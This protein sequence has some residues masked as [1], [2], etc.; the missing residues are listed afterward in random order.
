MTVAETIA[1]LQK[2]PQD[3]EVYFDCPRCGEA[4]TIHKTTKAVVVETKR[5]P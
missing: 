5:K 4:N 1:E 2:M 3:A